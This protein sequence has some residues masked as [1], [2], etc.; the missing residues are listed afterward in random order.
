MVKGFKYRSK[1]NDTRTKVKKIKENVQDLKKDSSVTIE[2]RWLKVG[3]ARKEKEIIKKKK[4]WVL[5]M[6]N[7]AI[8]IGLSPDV[9]RE[10]LKGFLFSSV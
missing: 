9:F 2:I 6:L 8:N 10:G 7:L 1:K 3:L 4:S 5:G